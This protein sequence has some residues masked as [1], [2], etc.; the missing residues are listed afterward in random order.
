M[1]KRLRMAMA[2]LRVRLAAWS[3]RQR[4]LAY[5]AALALCALMALGVYLSLRPAA[6]ND[7][8]R[9]RR[10]RITSNVEAS[11][12]VRASREAW[13]SLRSGGI[14]Q[15]VLVKPGQQVGRGD[16]L[17][18]TDS[19]EAEAQVR[20]AELN[21]QV[22]QIQLDDLKAAPSA[23]Q[24]EIAR[25]NLRRAAAVLQA[26]QSAYDRV[27]AG[28]SASGSSEA[29]ALES[30]KLDYETAKANFEQAIRGPT[31]SQIEIAEKSL[32]MAQLDLQNAQKR[33]EAVTVTAPFA[34]TVLQVNVREGETA[35]GA[36]VVRLADLATLEVSTQVDELDIGELEVGQEA[37]IRLDAF[38]GQVLSGRVA[39]LTPGAT[40]QRGT[41]GYEAVISFAPGSLAVRPDM[42]AN[43]RITTLTHDDT[44]LVPSRAVE[45]RGRNK[46]VRVVENGRTRDVQVTTGLSD[47]DSTEIL[48]GLKE[49]QQVAVR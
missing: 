5:G 10:G 19:A 17:V 40:P 18:R 12:A 22:R 27:A 24:I 25:A 21:L 49:G 14:V 4:R 8:A 44:L 36:Q 13:L 20:Q 38:P 7:V 2:E 45:A 41:V 11:G 47:A 37:E 34:G 16:A 30:A 33:L 32:E 6:P 1:I 43:L 23:A 28:G 31:P 48:D 35:Y 42:S 26:A 15:Q 29:A 46:Y 3:G 9:V 39:R